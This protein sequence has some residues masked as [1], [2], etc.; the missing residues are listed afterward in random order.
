MAKRKDG[1]EPV[2]RWFVAIPRWL[3][4]RTNQLINSHWAIRNRLKKGDADIIAASVLGAD[5]PR[6]DCR[7]RVSL[8]ITLGPGRR[9]PDPDAFWK[10]VLDGLVKCGAL[11]ND[12]PVWCELGTVDVVRGEQDG[13]VIILENHHEGGHKRK[14]VRDRRLSHNRRRRPLILPA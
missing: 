3:P 9:R 10:T 8:T 13:T 4:T 11:V 14:D 2:Q 5:V 1:D 7:R 12:S 6:A